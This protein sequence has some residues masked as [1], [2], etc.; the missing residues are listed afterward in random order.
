MV[1][2]TFYTTCSCS[3]IT[4]RGESE[5]WSD[6]SPSSPEMYVLK[7][8]IVLTSCRSNLFEIKLRKILLYIT[9]TRLPNI[10]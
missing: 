5:L 3:N 6:P 4:V 1:V 9:C 2:R 10:A 7:F 8:Y